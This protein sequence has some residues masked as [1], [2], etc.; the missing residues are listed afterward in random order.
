MAAGCSGENRRQ[1]EKQSPLGAYSWELGLRSP[2]DRLPE[3]RGADR[4]APAS[5]AWVGADAAVSSG[6]PSVHWHLWTSKL[7]V[8][9][10]SCG[11]RGD[12]C[13]RDN[14]VRLLQTRGGASPLPDGALRQLPLALEWH[15]RPSISPSLALHKIKGKSG[16]NQT[17]KSTNIGTTNTLRKVLKDQKIHC[18]KEEVV[19][20]KL[21]LREPIQR[22]PVIRLA[23]L[24][25]GALHILYCLSH[26][27]RD[28]P[29]LIV[30]SYV[31][32]EVTGLFSFLSHGFPEGVPKRFTLSGTFSQPDSR[33]T[34]RKSYFQCFTFDFFSMAIMNP[35]LHNLRGRQ[36][37][38]VL[39]LF[40]H[41]VKR[42]SETVVESCAID[43]YTFG[44]W[45]IHGCIHLGNYEGVPCRQEVGAPRNSG[46]S[47]TI[48]RTIPTIDANSEDECL[49]GLSEEEEEVSPEVEVVLVEAT[50]A[51][52]F[53]EL[54]VEQGLPCVPSANYL[55]GDLM[56]EDVRDEGVLAAGPQGGAWFKL[57][58]RVGNLFGFPTLILSGD[59]CNRPA[60]NKG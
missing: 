29:G 37:I 54:G 46:P 55:S 27:L 2:I 9:F 17:K 16:Q 36:L 60:I 23:L 45:L 51:L 39:N 31:E 10:F 47:A 26:K 18:G 7:K 38:L 5:P 34:K 48:S 49:D 44:R 33:R 25:L 6:W 21:Q 56:A 12:A 20:K 13:G 32:L 40:N 19:S 57:R 4:S 30:L 11:T 41:Q 58:H 43:C 1:P 59:A 15:P 42:K 28:G 35:G 8:C 53:D 22:F 14:L 50:S 3:C 52:G 24:P